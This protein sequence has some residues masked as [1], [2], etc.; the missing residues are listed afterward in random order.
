M[1]KITLGPTGDFP[2]GKLRDDDKGG[3]MVAVAA[4]AVQ[5]VVHID[6]G[7]KVAWVALPPNEARAFAA[8]LVAAAD[9]LDGGEKR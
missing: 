4:D 6:F 7:T 5:G 8:T 2:Q 1:V 3:L 9:K